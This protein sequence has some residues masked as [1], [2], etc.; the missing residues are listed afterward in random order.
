M[1]I[2]AVEQIV[3]DPDG[4]LLLRFTY[5]L[6]DDEGKSEVTLKDD[7]STLSILTQTVDS[8]ELSG[9]DVA[10]PVKAV[11]MLVSS[12]HLSLASPVFK[13]MLRGS[14]QESQILRELGMVDI[15]LP[16]DDPVH[17]EILLN[18]IHGYPKKVPTKVDLVTMTG[19]AILVDKYQMADVVY[20]YK[21]LWIQELKSDL[22]K[23][24]TTNQAMLSWLTVA[25]VFQLSD[26]FTQI[27]KLA[28][29]SCSGILEIP[30]GWN[31]PIPDYLLGREL[32][33]T[34]LESNSLMS[35]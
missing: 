30:P 12:K 18:I 5:P 27:T 19:L 3:F 22:P 20:M 29:Q 25:W 4:D 33:S 7:T 9:D 23:V 14:F 17:F 13:A 6:L 28:G 2:M 21:T 35:L 1:M 8:N 16:D 15:P 31:L 32:L 34:S 11:D 24:F 26:E 10:P